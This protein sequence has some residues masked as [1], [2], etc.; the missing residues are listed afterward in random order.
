L[1][2]AGLYIKDESPYTISEVYNNVF[3]NN[4]NTAII[5][6]AAN[7]CIDQNIFE[8]NTSLTGPAIL[9]G[10]GNGQS[11]Y[12]R[13]NILYKNSGK[14]SNG[15]FIENTEP[16]SG[17]IS[18]NIFW[19]NYTIRP[20]DIGFLD[21][22]NV[23]YHITN[24][25]FRGDETS[26]SVSAKADTGI[27]NNLFETYPDFSD[28]LNSILR[29]KE[30]SPLIDAGTDIKRIIPI[31]REYTTDFTG[32]PRKYGN[33]VDIGAYEYHPI[34]PLAFSYITPDT[35]ICGGA[36]ATIKAIP[37][38]EYKDYLYKY[39]WYKDGALLLYDNQD[40][41]YFNPFNF[42]HR[43]HYT[44]ALSNSV[45]TLWSNPI[46][47]GY[48]D[49]PSFIDG[50]LQ[51]KDVC[52][53]TGVELRAKT[54][55]LYAPVF[56]WYSSN[57]GQLP[58]TSDT[59]YIKPLEKNDTLHVT[60]TNVCG[61]HSATIELIAIPLPAPSLGNDIYIDPADSI[62]LD[63]KLRQ[64]SYLWSTGE[65]G[66]QIYA[67]AGDTVWLK[68]T[69]WFS[70]TGSDTIIIF[71]NPV[72]GVPSDDN[73]LSFLIYPNPAKDKL[74][75]RVADNITLPYRISIVSQDGKP[76]YEKEI[77]SWEEQMI[78][79]AMF[80]KGIY[81]IRIQSDSASGTGKFVVL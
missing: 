35:L 2:N 1:N 52:A 81:F 75:L 32:F 3:K 63:P 6:N 60:A 42:L 38:Q 12:F 46:I 26:I 22:T 18:N 74:F 54:E 34:A 58:S 16:C 21:S 68:V 50:D 62:L 39:N 80:G 14:N 37:V 47:V 20:Y 27:V 13:N 78:D 43:G 64:M 8:N 25:S 45:D 41:I 5:I 11:L 65:Q 76:I 71:A 10:F 61:S 55:S 29:L 72:T 33:A 23:G 28:T 57:N 7:T 66:K 44:V 70:C 24:N 56:N 79:V 48:E 53:G 36:S 67:H 15:I 51:K 49:P 19:N 73:N 30:S 40:R 31:S 4:K 17:R 59:C 9:K 77:S 69:D